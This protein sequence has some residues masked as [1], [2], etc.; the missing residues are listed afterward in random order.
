MSFG[1]HLVSTSFYR[2]SPR[3]NVIVS[4]HQ[5]LQTVYT[6]KTFRVIALISLSS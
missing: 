2:T 6:T 1:R 4:S 3:F 5:D